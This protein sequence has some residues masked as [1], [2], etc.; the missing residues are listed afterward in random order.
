MNIAEY[1]DFECRN[2][3]MWFVFESVSCN[4]VYHSELETCEFLIAFYRNWSVQLCRLFARS[5]WNN[6]AS[7][8]LS[9]HLHFYYRFRRIL[10]NFHRETVIVR[11]PYES[12][13]IIINCHRCLNCSF[14]Y[15]TLIKLVWYS[16]VLFI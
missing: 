2:S 3:K 6:L 9:T 14:A 12:Y 5:Y 13:L 11:F 15:I 8:F 4:W 1:S 16:H 10:E 7:F